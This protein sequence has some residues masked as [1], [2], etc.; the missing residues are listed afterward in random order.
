M[1][2]PLAALALASF[3]ASAGAQSIPDSASA[4]DLRLVSEQYD[5]SD[6]DEDGCVSLS[7]C[8]TRCAHGRVRVRR[9][10]E[11]TFADAF[12]ARA[13]SRLCASWVCSNAGFGIELDAKAL[14]T[15]VY[16]GAG[17]IECVGMSRPSASRAS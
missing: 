12:A 4:L 17:V 13:S 3:A 8:R 5:N 10:S 7:L 11:P 6:L 1:L 14:L 2:A 9:R 16:P 15:V